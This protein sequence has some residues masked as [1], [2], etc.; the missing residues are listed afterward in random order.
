M[1]NLEMSL[2]DLGRSI[3]FGPGK[4]VVPAIG[5]ALLY[6]IILSVSGQKVLGLWSLLSGFLSGLALIDLGFSGYLK[7]YASAEHDPYLRRQ[8]CCT[9]SA[10]SARVYLVSA[11]FLLAVIAAAIVVEPH[12]TESVSQ[13]YSISGFWFS[14]IICLCTSIVQLHTKLIGA[15]LA[16]EGLNYHQEFVAGISPLVTFPIALAG[17]T[18]GVPLEGLT[19]GYFSAACVSNTL[20]ARVMSNRMKLTGRKL[21]FG[22]SVNWNDVRT[23]WVASK[24]FYFVSVG[25][26]IRDPALRFVSAS[27]AGLEITGWIDIAMRLTAMVR[28]II[29]SG[30]AVLFPIVSRLSSAG[31]RES[32]RAISEVSLGYLLTYVTS[33]ELLLVVGQAEIYQLWLGSHSD[34]LLEATL[35]FSL[36]NIFVAANVPFWHMLLASGK[37]GYA[38]LALWLHTAIVLCLIPASY[39]STI[40]PHQIFAWWII[41]ALLTQIGIYQIV[42]SQFGILSQVLRQ[43]KLMLLLCSCVIVSIVVYWRAIESRG[44]WSLFD[45]AGLV[46]VAALM[47][48]GTF[49][50]YSSWRSVKSG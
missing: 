29:S 42:Q 45:G 18:I 9:V 25:F 4:F 2:R 44:S 32:I 36:W 28:N 1:Q 33:A 43:G 10:A 41:G 13:N 20:L 30:T 38:A 8:V 48:F 49:V 12:W 17:A 6:P 35:A 34:V 21:F 7:K 50:T 31:D 40:G 19:V 5:Y 27:V 14:V 23:L 46:L 24:Q 22:E 16:S 39:L 15:A 3:L 47:V 26:A 11:I 37:E